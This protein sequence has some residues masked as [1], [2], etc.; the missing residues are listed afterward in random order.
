MRTVTVVAL[1]LGVSF[2]SAAN[3]VASATTLSDGTFNNVAQTTVFNSDPTGTTVTTASGP[4]C[5]CGNGDAAGIQVFSNFSQSTLPSNTQINTAVGFVDNALSYN[6][7]T[8]GAIGSITASADKIL[9]VTVPGPPNPSL[10]GNTFRPMIEQGGIFYL[11]AIP[12]PGV[13][14]PGST[15]WNTLSQAGLTASAFTQYDF[16]T[17]TFGTANPDFAGG[18][19]LFG[20]AQLTGFFPGFTATADYDNLSFT[21]VPTPLPAALPLF[22]TG[23]GALGLLGWR[24]KKKA[25]TGAA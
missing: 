16:T 6:P 19:M 2:L 11:A 17:G 25:Q 20:L 13:P 8:Q 12:G 4:T 3:T 21:L 14:E 24:R 23:L 7:S 9:T 1:A 10:G 5:N 18:P 15:G 22:A